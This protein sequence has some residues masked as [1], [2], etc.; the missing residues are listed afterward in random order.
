M[1]NNALTAKTTPFVMSKLKIVFKTETID[2][3]EKAMK[4]HAIL[5]ASFEPLGIIDEWARERDHIVSISRT[6]DKEQLPDVNSFDFLVI[7]GGPQSSLETS[8]YPY[9]HDEIALIKKAIK[10]DKTILGICLGAQLIGDALG[11]KPEQS[12]KKEV[13][14]F[15][16]EL[17]KAAENDPLFS[18]FPK[19][20]DVM[21]WHNDMPG[22]PPNATIL[23]S[24]EGC[25]RQI[26][27]FSPKVYGF[28]CHLEITPD[29]LTGLIK[30][31]PNDLKEDQFVQN[32]EKMLSYNLDAI[33]ARMKEILDRMV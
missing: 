22:V 18:D 25:T 24:S 3:Q 21:H 16:I 15:P 19:I 27:R 17:T 13:G 14:V 33:N 28:Q 20:F 12:P 1:N 29:V 2:K 32:A 23:A 5:H 26:I 10:E 6:Y 11:A 30:H 4:I 7:M 8:K 31:C 9:L